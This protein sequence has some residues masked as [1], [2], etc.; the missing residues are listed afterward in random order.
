MEQLLDF[1]VVY[2]DGNETVTEKACSLTYRDMAELL[3]RMEKLGSMIDTCFPVISSSE[4]GDDYRIWSCTED[5]WVAL[6]DIQ[7]INQDGRN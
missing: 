6:S 3:K 5:N 7:P 1:I 2:Y 4:F